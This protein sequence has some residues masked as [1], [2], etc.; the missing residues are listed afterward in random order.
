MGRPFGFSSTSAISVGTTETPILALRGG[1]INYFHQNI[2]PKTIDLVDTA[3]NNATLWRIRIY[4]DLNTTNDVAS[5]WTPVNSNYSVS[6]YSI[7]FTT[8]NTINSIVVS[9]GIFSG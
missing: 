8:W 6:E 3:N 7:T 1:G 4:Q 5:N 9:Q 2:I